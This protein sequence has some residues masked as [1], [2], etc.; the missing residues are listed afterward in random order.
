LERLCREIQAAER[1]LNAAAAGS[2]K[3]CLAECRGLCCRNLHLDAVF[4]VADFVYILHLAPALA[5][6]TAAC[7]ENENPLFSSD[8]FFLADGVGP[9]LFP[10][11]LRPELCITSF[12]R[13]DDPLGPEI[14]RVRRGFQKLGFLAR[15]P[16]RAGIHHFLARAF[17]IPPG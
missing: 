5:E 9:C 14:R 3:G 13:G 6:K 12:C 2:L 17:R 7:L 4:G 8:C 1:R 16:G 11:D 15:F 10:P